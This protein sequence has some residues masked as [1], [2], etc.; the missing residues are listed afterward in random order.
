[1]LIHF[2]LPLFGLTMLDPVLKSMEIDA[3]NETNLKN[4]KDSFLFLNKTCLQA[5]DELKVILTF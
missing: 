1:M 5:F 3:K 2:S 4:I